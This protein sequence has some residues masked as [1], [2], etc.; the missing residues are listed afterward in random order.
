MCPVTHSN[1]TLDTLR[2]Q[3]ERQRMVSEQIAQR[4]IDDPAILHAFSSVPR[5]LFTLPRYRDWAY[6]DAPIPTLAKQTI[7]QPYV[8]ALM[9]SL[10]RLRGSYRVLE[11]GAGSGYAAALLSRIVKEV[12]TVERH[13]ELA[14]F[15]REKLAEGNFDNVVV[16]CGDGTRG[17]PEAAPFDAII[18]AASGP[19]IPDTLK[20]Q[21]SVGGRLVMPVGK[22]RSQQHLVVVTRNREDSFEVEHHVGVA[23]VP[24]IGEAG[25]PE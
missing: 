18:V 11:I 19:S 1:D 3:R 12:Y 25:W 24:L 7:S 17:W 16:R 20:Q 15:A 10:L 13:L 4:G 8:V 21:L 23:F 9:L 6:D 14:A 5:E 2:F 22:D